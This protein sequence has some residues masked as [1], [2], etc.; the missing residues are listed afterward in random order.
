[1]ICLEQSHSADQNLHCIALDGILHS[2][3]NPALPGPSA[4]MRMEFRG[5]LFEGE[6]AFLLL[7]PPVIHITNS[8]EWQRQVE[9]SYKLSVGIVGEQFVIVIH[10][11]MCKTEKEL[12]G[13]YRRGRRRRDTVIGSLSVDLYTAK[14]SHESQS[15]MEWGGIPQKAQIDIQNPSIHP[16]KRA[17]VVMVVPGKSCGILRANNKFTIYSNRWI[18]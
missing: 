3:L 2:C 6:G 5:L 18:D 13:T 10:S 4:G 14:Y 12:L 16:W 11:F 8:L 15:V 1:M 17:G 9:F 7:L